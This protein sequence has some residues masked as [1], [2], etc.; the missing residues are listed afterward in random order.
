MS[1]RTNLWKPPHW[2]RCRTTDTVD[3]WCGPH[4]RRRITTDTLDIRNRG[5]YWQSE[6]RIGEAAVPGPPASGIDDPDCEP[7]DEYEE[8]E[9]ASQSWSDGPETLPSVKV[10]AVAEQETPSESHCLVGAE[11]SEDISVQARDA[12]ASHQPSAG[13]MRTDTH[14]W[15]MASHGIWVSPFDRDATS[16]DLSAGP[17]RAAHVGLSDFVSATKFLGARVGAAFRTGD[18]GLGYYPDVRLVHCSGV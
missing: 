2:R 9:A 15:G 11:I 7:F 8:V 18:R 4:C 16:P 10:I 12:S 1:L 13:A 17:A 5:P 14:G 6:A 3:H